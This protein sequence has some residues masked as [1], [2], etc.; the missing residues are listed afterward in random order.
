MSSVQLN[1][2]K[3]STNLALIQELSEQ[4][5]DLSNNIPDTTDF[6]KL[7]DANT[8]TEDNTFQ[9]DKK[10]IVNI[11]GS[12]T[13]AISFVGRET[14][15]QSGLLVGAGP[16]AHI[17]AKVSGVLSVNQSAQGGT[18][19]RAVNYITTPKVEL[20][21]APVDAND[22]TNKNYVD[23]SLVAKQDT[24]TNL[25]SDNFLTAGSN[26][27]LTQN[28]INT[29]INSSSPSIYGFRAVGNG[30]SSATTGAGAVI[31]S[32][33][34]ITTQSESSYDT[35]GL[36]GATT[37]GVFIPTISGWY[38]NTCKIFFLSSSSTGGNLI[39]LMKNQSAPIQ[40]DVILTGGDFK[41]QTG[42]FTGLV[43]MVAGTS[44]SIRQFSGS[45][46]ISL[47]YNHS[48]WEC[49]LVQET[50]P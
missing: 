29:T 22:A 42:D 17:D 49:E 8:F 20:T 46:T 1:S 40:A 18:D 27:T 12:P 39:S 43:Y 34:A 45:A 28:G 2:N 25:V 19:D 35:T 14:N 33:L 47:L 4:V 31:S 44:Y 38:R 15:I 23:T 6:A 48:W 26:I 11:T 32:V 13:S 41:G 30:I 10:F 36:Y 37:N 5:A 9:G 3:I 24:I 21:T 50:I 16:T 7:N